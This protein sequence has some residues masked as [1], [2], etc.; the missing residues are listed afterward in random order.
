M[1]VH[2]RHRRSRRRASGSKRHDRTYDLK[3][4]AE[5]HAA[6][7]N[8]VRAARL[9][10]KH[11]KKSGRGT[12]PRVRVLAAMNLSAVE[13]RYRVLQTEAGHSAHS[14]VDTPG[15]GAR[16]L[17]QGTEPAAAAV[18]P[19]E[20]GRDLP[21][22]PASSAPVV[23]P[24]APS[25]VEAGDAEHSGHVTLY[26]AKDLNRWLAEHHWASGL[27]Y[28]DIVLDAVNWAAAG[29]Q[30]TEIFSPDSSTVPL[31]DI[32]ARPRV[33][34]RPS[35]GPAEAETRAVRFHRNHM[36]VINRLAGTW[37][38]GNRNALL[39]D[40]LTAYREAHRGH[41]GQDSV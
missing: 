15:V 21:S 25:S 24:V 8:E 34:S 37:T 3:I 36:K 19:S 2:L 14:L 32:F 17:A 16:N 7:W 20:E 27:S 18:E 23:P 26:L 5:E 11:D 39:V 28:Q 30:L 35:L 10:L 1:S 13:R 22:Q 29:D 40:A 4:S 6:L 33:P 31:N 12:P 9:R 38:G 41:D